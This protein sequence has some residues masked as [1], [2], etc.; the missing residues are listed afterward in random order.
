M[1]FAALYGYSIPRRKD[2]QIIAVDDNS[3]ENK[4]DFSKFP[5]L[6][7]KH[8]EVYIKEEGKGAGYARNVGMEH[9]NGKRLLFADIL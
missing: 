7:D 2:I 6:D 1:P 3:D 5:W 8:V 9:A 4:V